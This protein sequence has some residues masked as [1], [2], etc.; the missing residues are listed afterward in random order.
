MSK[1]SESFCDIIKENTSIVIKELES[2]LPINFQ[3][4]SDIYKEYF[5]IIDD[6][7]GACYL[8]ESEMMEK[9]IPTSNLKWI[10]AY[11]KYL[12]Q[13]SLKQIESYNKFLN[14]Y[15]QMRIDGMKNYEVYAHSMI[16]TYGKMLKMFTSTYEK[17]ETK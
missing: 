2:Q 1:E 3:M 4:Y 9:I 10:D 6:L 5:H 16:D 15:S 8:V 13:I 11:G 12:T 17:Q 7:F 14:W